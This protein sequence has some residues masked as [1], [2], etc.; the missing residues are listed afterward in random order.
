M[1]SSRPENKPRN[2]NFFAYSQPIVFEVEDELYQL[3]QFLLPHSEKMFAL[4]PEL[5]NADEGV[6]IVVSNYPKTFF[7]AFLTVL[8]HPIDSFPLDHPCTRPLEL[9]VLIE[10]L[11]IA[12]EWGMEEMTSSIMEQCHGKFESP[13]D[14]LVIGQRL[15]ILPWFRAGLEE[16]VRTDN[17]IY[18]EEANAIGTA[19]TLRIYHARARCSR[20]LWNSGAGNPTMALVPKV[21]EEMFAEIWGDWENDANP[22]PCFQSTH[23]GPPFDVRISATE[24]D[25][26]TPG[27]AAEPCPNVQRDSKLIRTLVRAILIPKIREKKRILE[28]VP[29]LCK[30]QETNCGTTVRCKACCVKEVQ[31]YLPFPADV[32]ARTALGQVFVDHICEMNTGRLR[33]NQFVLEN[34]P[35]VCQKKSCGPSKRCAKC[36]RKVAIELMGEGGIF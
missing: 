28:E 13:I 19:L 24:K 17:D 23:T 10:A 5:K 18:I 3:P 26:D 12:N 32:K 30:K 11:S 27:D 1:L 25:S 4:Y 20:E 33:S 35:K 9:D 21:V 8:L 15:Q 22:E 34:V 2:R 6:K 16:L 36:C 31:Q 14:K 29:K 7:E